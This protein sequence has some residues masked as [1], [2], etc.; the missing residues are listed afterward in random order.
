MQE[1]I[2]GARSSTSALV[3][4]A[5]LL[6]RLLL[7]PFL[8]FLGVG[9]T[10]CGSW[11]LLGRIAAATICHPRPLRGDG[12]HRCDG[13][14]RHTPPVASDRLQLIVASR[15]LATFQDLQPMGQVPVPPPVPLQELLWYRHP[16]A[17]PH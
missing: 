13:L 7:Q 5:T 8:L 15:G 1:S 6:H 4:R 2:A 11:R 17:P 10:A 14:C 3:L 16:L 12:G 9:G